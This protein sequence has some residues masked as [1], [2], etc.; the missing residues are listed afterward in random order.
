MYDQ[1]EVGR[2][3]RELR[4]QRNYTQIDIAEK[5]NVSRQAVS[6]WE[7]GSS[8][9]ETDKLI[10]LGE[11]YGVSVD[12]LLGRKKKEL[13]QGESKESSPQKKGINWEYFGLIVILLISSTAPPVGT[14]TSIVV[15]V[16]LIKKK[17]IYKIVMVVSVVCLVFN[18]YFLYSIYGPAE[19]VTH[20]EKID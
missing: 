15:L 3:L 10:L 5:L 19:E 9:P 17:K 14:I 2:K 20:I 11:L 6:R 16:W 1:V 4:M 18:I 12:E 7:T 13:R 8:C